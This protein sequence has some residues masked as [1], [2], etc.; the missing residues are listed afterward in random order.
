[1]LGSASTEMIKVGPCVGRPMAC[2]RSTRWPAARSEEV[3][4]TVGDVLQRARLLADLG[5]YADVDPL[6]A[7]VL[8]GEPDNADALLLLIEGQ[9]VRGRFTQAAAAAGQLLRT[10]PNNV[11]GLLLMARMRWALHGAR[12]GVPFA[13]RAV[14]LYPDDV[15][16]LTTLA[17]VL[18]GVTTGS[19]EALTL[20]ERAITIDPDY[21]FAYLV[22]GRIHLDALQYLEAEHWTLEAL[23]ITPADPGA[24]LQLGLV[25][26]GLGRFEESREA[27][28]AALRIDP[29]PARIDELI[30][31]VEF[32]AIP[33]HF[34]EIYRMML[35]GR[36][37]PD[38]S[39]PGAAE[40][41]PALIA[42]Q[43]ALA[44]RM[45]SRQ[46]TAEGLRRASELADAVLAVD[47][48]NQHARHVRSQTL[49]DS[50][51]YAE[52]LPL[53]EQL[54]A[55]GYPG[56]DRAVYVAQM[57]AGSCSAALG[58]IQRALLKDPGLPMYLLAEA[59][60]LGLLGRYDEALEDLRRVGERTVGH[61]S[62]LLTQIGWD[63]KSTGDRVAAE[64]AWRMAMR[65]APDEGTPAAEVALLLAEDGRWPEAAA[66]MA[67]LRPDMPDLNMARYSC[68][69]LLQA[70]LT[71]AG[72]AFEA[73][74][75]D[76]PDAECG[77]KATHWLNLIFDLFAVL[78]SG[79]PEAAATLCPDWLTRL[80]ADLR[81][82][83]VLECR[84]FTRVARDLHGLREVWSPQ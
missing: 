30:A 74:H 10:D 44:D 26:A 3:V 14:E 66:V 52:A 56:A 40:E 61:V 39:H 28:V 49:S 29:Q 38:L 71:A 35:V 78:D 47:P 63:A 55:E 25:R 27:V 45:Y 83:S 51:R 62:A 20:V 6:V 57:G 17:D 72:A 18:E 2:Q 4:V 7:Q 75:G 34:A 1:M 58:T 21:A 59:K 82:G 76:D 48:G 22:A 42:A 64:R 33:D 13:R 36:R 81:P 11:G 41:D 67:T 15:T 43:G 65:D 79:R 9:A 5:R 80:H 32:L 31:H 12:E 73:K 77:E 68:M 8:A 16:C 37:L 70:C 60:C 84:E 23:K 46:A 53:A 69:K 19:V 54:M 50:G 24:V